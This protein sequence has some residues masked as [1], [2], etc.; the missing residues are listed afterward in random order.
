MAVLSPHINHGLRNTRKCL[1]SPNKI[2]CKE[3]MHVWINLRE[4]LENL[5][6]F[7]TLIFYTHTKNLFLLRSYSENTSYSTQDKVNLFESSFSLNRIFIRCQLSLYRRR[8]LMLI[9]KTTDPGGN[10]PASKSRLYHMWGVSL[11]NY[12]ISFSFLIFEIEVIVVLVNVDVFQFLN[13]LNMQS[14]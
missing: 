3:K 9:A 1:L 5:G 7:P 4:K 14:T 8:Q 13:K 10:L 12:L 6:I 2:H 11:G